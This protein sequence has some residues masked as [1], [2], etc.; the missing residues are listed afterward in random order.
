MEI[1]R[2]NKWRPTLEARMWETAGKAGKILMNNLNKNFWTFGMDDPEGIASEREEQRRPWGTWM[3]LV[4]RRNWKTKRV[5]SIYQWYH[6]HVLVFGEIPFFSHDTTWWTVRSQTRVSPSRRSSRSTAEECFRLAV[7]SNVRR[8]DGLPRCRSVRINTRDTIPRV[9]VIILC[10]Y[11]MCNT[12][13]RKRAN[14]P[15]SSD[16]KT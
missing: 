11:K 15:I 3:E 5:E 12:V 7:G 6:T 13:A 9:N 14:R 16:D 8:L 4:G 2:H 10:R 1:K